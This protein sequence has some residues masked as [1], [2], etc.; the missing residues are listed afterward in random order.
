MDVLPHSFDDV[1]L[2]ATLDL[3]APPPSSSP[4]STEVSPPDCEKSPASDATQVGDIADDL[5]VTA[6]EVFDA[7]QSRAGA[8][9]LPLSPHPLRLTLL[10]LRKLRGDDDQAQVD[11]KERTN[12]PEHVHDELR[13]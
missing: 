10:R 13:E 5:V 9:V 1:E 3:L 4:L 2:S 11:H 7:R 12:L 8:G 6:T